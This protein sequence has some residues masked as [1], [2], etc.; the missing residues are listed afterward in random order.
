[1]VPGNFISTARQIKWKT[2]SKG[3]SRSELKILLTG[4]GNLVSL[5]RIP[6][7]KYILRALIADYTLAIK[8]ISDGKQTANP[9][10]AFCNDYL[11]E[12]K[13]TKSKAILPAK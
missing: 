4:L 3:L 5:H 13:R 1:M 2:M 10:S 7:A 6:P 8:I 11:M 12:A 9:G